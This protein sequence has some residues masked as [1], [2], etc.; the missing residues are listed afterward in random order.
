MCV[1]IKGNRCCAE[2]PRRSL[3]DIRSIG[4]ADCRRCPSDAE[5][6]KRVGSI[7]QVDGL[8]CHPQVY[9]ASCGQR[10]TGL[11]DAVRTIQGEWY[12][13]EVDIALNGQSAAV[14]RS[15]KGKASSTG[16]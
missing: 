12:A 1:C 5:G 10:T 14:I 3:E 8:S 11:A 4:D 7:G 6:A 16:G 2:I 9:V 15:S 13:S